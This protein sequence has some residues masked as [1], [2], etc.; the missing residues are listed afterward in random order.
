MILTRA[1]QLALAPVL[2][3]QAVQVIR[4]TPR[5]PE[6]S[7]PR[8]GQEG[9]GP[10]LRVLILGDSSAA[11]VGAPTQR[12]A[13]SGQLVQALG[14]RATVMWQLVAR[15]GITT[16]SVPALLSSV[17]EGSFDIALTALGV[18]DVTRLTHPSRWTRQTQALHHTLRSRY[19]VRRIYATTVPPLD[20]FPALPRPLSTVLGRHAQKLSEALEGVAQAAPDVRLL[21]PDWGADTTGMASDGFHPGPEIYRHW[22]HFAAQFIHEDLQSHPL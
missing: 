14:A 11:G 8:A 15:T 7:G 22:G 17:G 1:Q 4:R 2:A 18:N 19:A 10:R 3:V 6:A 16:A 20:Q 12:A 5:L 13:L 21:H 9:Q